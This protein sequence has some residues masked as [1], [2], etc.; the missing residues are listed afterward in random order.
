[1]CVV[2]F[3]KLFVV[4]AEEKF[5]LVNKFFSVDVFKVVEM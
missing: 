4:I 5:V 2:E 1:M 3:E